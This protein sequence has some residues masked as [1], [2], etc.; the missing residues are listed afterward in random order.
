[1]T[2]SSGTRI[3]AYEIVALIGSGGMGEVYRARDERLGRDVAI[4]VLPA[5][6]TR[7][8]DRLRRFEQEARAAAALNHPNIL[9]VHEI[10]TYT[11][12]PERQATL[13]VVSELL[14]GQTLRDALA[15]GALTVRKAVDYATQIASGLA[16]AHEKGIV[17]RDLKPE[18]LFVTRDGRIKIL[19]FGL[20]KLREPEFDNAAAATALATRH[21]HT[22][23][24]VVLGTAGYMSPE[25]VRA[26]PVDHRTDIFSFGAVLYEMLSGVRAFRGETAADTISAILRN[27]PPELTSIH[28]TVPPALERIIHHCLE[29]T[30][31]LRFQAARDIVFNLE[32][33]S[34]T[35]ST[36][37]LPAAPRKPRRRLIAA[38]VAVGI[39]ALAAAA[40][41]RFTARSAEG[42]VFRQITFRHGTLGNARF[43]ADGQNIVYTASWE[44]APSEVFMV[45]AT[46]TGGRSLEMKDAVLLAVSKSG[47]IAVALAPKTLTPFLTPGT[48]ARGA[49]A[50]GAPKAEIENILAAD[51][52]PDGS[53]L[54]IVRVV[55]D[56]RVCQLE[57]PIGTVLFRD[58]FLSDVRFS[59]D[60]KYLGLIDHPAAGDDRG[61]AVI[62]RITG[63]RVATGP[64]RESHRGLVWSPA[65][66]EVW[67]TAPLLNGT[68]LA[69]DLRGRSRELLNVPGKLFVRDTTTQGQL[70]L[71]EGTS[72]RGIMVASQNAENQ[73]DLSWLDYSYLR[74]ISKDGRML[75]FEEEGN[76]AREGYRTFVRN[77]DGSP[78]VEVGSG[79]GVAISDDKSQV[80]SLRL[81]ASGPELWLN[82]VGAGQ[83]KRLSPPNLVPA[84]PAAAFFADGKRIVYAAR[85][86]DQPA[87]LYVQAIDGSGAKALS[88]EFL[89]APLIS[90]D[91]KWIAANSAAGPV[92]VPVDGGPVTRIQGSRPGDSLRGWTNDGQI[93]VA[94]GSQTRGRID[95]LNPWTGQRTLWR[96][97]TLPAIVGVRIAA[98]FITP[99]GSTYAYGYSLASSDLYVVTGVH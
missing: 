29:K 20:A 15:G 59:P 87:R 95:K 72:R 10:G 2:I 79:Y 89:N 76:A 58:A 62:L 12:A 94:S 84:G 88:S 61:S 21:V 44:A 3:A 28:T 96:E 9:T 25:Q 53:S 31:E 64:L 49:I 67:T 14:E 24:G 6:F 83:A 99:D 39:V 57:Y 35:T 74:G 92:L 54:A 17:H 1:M 19:D 78:A 51:Y 91:Q 34:T 66:D 63:Q 46:Q 16:A 80:L 33:L 68:L 90:L 56:Q 23:A 52:A 27:D 98:P 38:A 93:F 48:L 4:K 70:L 75:V 8:P 7:D 71:E 82:P 11:P 41:W 37:V 40:A 69:L 73:R 18:N 26:Q 65:G 45:P 86:G 85:E 77:V 22:G 30:P 60:G 81:P 13:Y 55:P 50:G 36:S 47:E 32:A 97:L 5:A 43:T 42:P